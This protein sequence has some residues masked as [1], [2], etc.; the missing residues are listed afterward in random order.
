MMWLSLY[1]GEMG[2]ITGVISVHLRHCLDGICVLNVDFD[3]DVE[4]EAVPP[5]E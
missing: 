5:E 3:F 1:V 2:M 4:D